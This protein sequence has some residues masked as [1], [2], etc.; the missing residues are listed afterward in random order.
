MVSDL[1][2]EQDILMTVDI[3][4]GFHH[5]QLHADSQTYFGMFWKDQFY[6]WCVL[7]FGIAIAPYY[8]HKV[9]RPVVQHLRQQ[10]QIRLAPFVDDFLLMLAKKLALTQSKQVLQMLQLLGWHPNLEKCDLSLTTQM[11]FIGFDINSDTSEGPW[12]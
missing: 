9:I 4:D 6:V 10:Q 8:F 11:T 5:V 2:Q 1:I 3:K 12:I 7:C